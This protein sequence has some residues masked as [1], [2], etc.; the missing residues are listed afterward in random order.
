MEPEKASLWHQHRRMTEVYLF[1]EGKGIFCYNQDSL[2]AERDAYQVLPPKTPHKTINASNRQLEHL[3]FA[4]PPFDPNDV[5]L[6]QEFK[7]HISRPRKFSYEKPPTT[8]LDGALIHELIP[9]E[10]R[11]RLDVGLAIGYLPKGRRA[12]PHY[13]KISEELYY[14]AS[15]VGR[16]NVGE[17]RFFVKKGSVV[18]VPVN[19][20]HALENLSKTE[21][22]RV[23]C[24]TSPAYTEGD[25]IFYPGRS[26]KKSA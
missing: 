9:Q 6:T 1:L 14:V 2:L 21:D 19:S 3:V 16:V 7:D 4:I 11:E 24:V 17:E 18:S 23:V 12:Y 10:E 5:E 26:S 20:V 13:H 22:L 25:F 8:A 15:G